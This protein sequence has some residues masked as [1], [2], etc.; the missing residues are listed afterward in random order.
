MSCSNGAT[1][2]ISVTV[3]IA[4]TDS[5]TCTFTNYAK[6]QLN[7]GTNV[8]QQSVTASYNGNRSPVATQ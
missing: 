6:V 4:A 8:T 2:D 3:T 1:G 7:T 5:I